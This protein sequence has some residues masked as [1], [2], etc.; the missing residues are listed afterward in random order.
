[1]RLYLSSFRMGND[2]EKF[3][4][5]VT[6]NKRAAVILNAHDYFPEK[7]RHHALKEELRDLS[8]IG[9]SSEEI[10][11]RKYYGDKEGLE[12]QLM[13]YDSVW[14]PG[15]DSFLLRR[16]MYDSGFDIIIKNMLNE[17]K[18]VYAGY[19]AGVVVLAPTLRGLEIA[20]DDTKVFSTYKEECI[21]DGLNVLQYNIVPHFKSQH[22][23]SE[24]MDKVVEYFKSENMNYKTL[25][26][27]QALI[28]NGDNEQMI[29]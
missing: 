4:E 28:I 22:G 20:D 12:Q 17:D 9:L 19:S 11:L 7:E 2:P 26:D 1:M 5:L 6:G 8:K 29:L 10:D 16:A 23:K 25:M 13:N 3:S 24:S 15:G 27:G 18:I 21:Y 14:I